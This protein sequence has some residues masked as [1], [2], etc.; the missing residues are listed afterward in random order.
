[1]KSKNKRCDDC[2]QFVS[3]QE[4]RSHT[5]KHKL[6]AYT[7]SFRS[8][9]ANILQAQNQP[10]F[11]T[12]NV[13][14]VQDQPCSSTSVSAPLIPEDQSYEEYNDY[15]MEIDNIVE[16]NPDVVMNKSIREEEDNYQE[17]RQVEFI[18][19]SN[20]L[21]TLLRFKNQIIVPLCI[22]LDDSSQLTSQE[23]SSLS[24]N[25]LLKDKNA[26]KNAREDIVKWLNNHF[27]NTNHGKHNATE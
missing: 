3:A 6:K 27:N 5:K 23:R 20:L 21:E 22:K 13:R 24:F 17:G 11:S 9:K 10:C 1:M 26:T 18:I 19:E 16:E 15:D 7:T 8:F 4:W 14:Q 12:S 2:G 25:K